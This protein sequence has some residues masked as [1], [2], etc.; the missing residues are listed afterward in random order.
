MSIREKLNAA[1]KKHRK[2][3][4]EYATQDSASDWHREVLEPLYAFWDSANRD[5]FEGACVKPHILLNEPKVPQALGDHANVSGWG[6]RNQIRVRPSLITGKH[7]LLREGDEFAEGRMRFVEDVLLHE[8]VHQYC[9]EMLHTPENSYKGHGPT[10]AGECNRIGATLG[11][12]PVRPAK[13]RGKL[14]ELPS[15]AQ[16]PHNVRDPAYYLGALA[17]PEPKAG[18]EDDAGE[19]DLLTFPCPLDPEEAIPV[20]LAHFDMIGV[21]I[22]EEAFMEVLLEEEEK[23]ERRERASKKQAAAPVASNGD[24]KAQEPKQR[25]R[26]PKQKTAPVSSNGDSRAQEPKRRGRPRKHKPAPGSA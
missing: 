10:F 14:K 12:P 11:L 26:P 6:S 16:W 23:Q 13:A 2:D 7:K 15:C 21:E 9:D 17:D 20:L 19:E 22:I 3:F 24:G 8:S 18:D 4:A 5:Y 1:D 25:G